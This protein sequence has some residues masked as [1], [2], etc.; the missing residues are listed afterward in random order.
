MRILLVDDD[1]ELVSMMSDYLSAEGF[2]ICIASDIFTAAAEIN[3][4]QF[5]LIV[6]DIMMPGGNGLEFLAKLRAENQ[7]IPVIILSAKGDDMD[8]ILGLELGAD[9][10]V[11]KPCTPRELCARIKAIGKRTK[12][13]ADSNFV[14]NL[15]LLKINIM[16][17]QVIYDQLQIN[18]TGAEYRLLKQLAENLGSSVSKQSLS[19]EAL[20][21]DIKRFDRSI[22]VHISNIRKKLAAAGCHDVIIEAVLRRGYQMTKLAQN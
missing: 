2:D 17:R 3:S 7:N 10:Y 12:P 9:D 13:A 6:L 5:D 18:V 11:A 19:R 1:V 4:S 21:K 16:R 15:G 8:R 22:D 20:G 14:P